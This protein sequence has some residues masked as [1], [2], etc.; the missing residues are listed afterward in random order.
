V[1][2]HLVRHGRP[3]VDRDVPA[4]EWV[5]DPASY[6]DVWALRERL[7]TRATWFTSPEPRAV[8]TAQLLSDAATG[9][10]D[11]LR[12]HERGVGWV[13]DFPDAVRRAFERPDEAAS[14]GWEPLSVCRARVV[15]A[16]G[17]ILAAHAGEDVVLVGHGTVWAV[18][19][20]ALTGTPPDPVRW[21]G[22]RMP[23]TI[24]L[25]LP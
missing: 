18:L 14:P 17:P 16:V 11:G 19:A 6:D 13:D 24:C 21:A 20:A 10:V 7:P 4:R 3:V 23:D 12:E 1:T 9:I 2:L 22:P 15:G 5:L 8:E 25:D